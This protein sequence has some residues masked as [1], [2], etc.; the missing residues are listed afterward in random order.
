MKKLGTKIII[1]IVACSVIMTIM[2]GL[3]VMLVSTK[4]IDKEAKDKLLYISSSRGNEF[5]ILTAKIE[6]TVNDVAQIILSEIDSSKAI[7]DIYMSSFEQAHANMFLQI[8]ESKK[9]IVGLYFNFDPSFT[10]GRKG[11][12][13]AYLFDQETKQTK[14]DLDSYGIEEYDVANEDL[15][16][17][18]NPVKAGHG[19]WSMPYVDSVSNVNMISYTMPV[20]LNGKLV[21]V[22]GADIS[23]EY[24]RSLILGTKLYDTGYAF[25]LSEDLTFIV[26]KYIDNSETKLDTMENSI[27]K[28]LALDIKSQKQDITEITYR[29]KKSIM[30]YYKLDNGMVVG[31]VAPISE[32]NKSSLEIIYLIIAISLSGIILSFVVGFL[33]SRR[34]SIPIEYVSKV[35]LKTSNFD[36]TQKVSDK[37]LKY[38]DEIGILSNSIDTMQKA[39]REVFQDLV[40]EADAVKESSASTESEINI[41]REDINDISATTEELSA[42]MEETSASAQQM[43]STS[44]NLD[45]AVL[46]ISVKAREGAQA[47]MVISERAE[48]LK[49]NA[50]ISQKSAYDTHSD[51]DAKLQE[52]I[53]Q[54]KAIEQ[55]GTI[56]ES[57]LQITEQTN[58]L[59]LN[60]SI[61]AARA[62]EAGKGFAVVASEIRKL[63]DDSKNAVSQIQSVANQVVYSVENLSNN[64]KHV[65]EFIQMQVIK[66]YDAM[67]GIGEQYCEDA[68]Y[69]HSLVNEFS[70]ASNLLAISIQNMV[71]S[72]N[73]ISVANND[74]TMAVQSIVEKTSDVSDKANEVV[75]IAYSTKEI[76][77]R[78]MTIMSKFKV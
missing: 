6:N 68:K 41:L 71:K 49:T 54:A 20:Y 39:I 27:Y 57:I 77:H 32:V 35:L 69:V 38:K 11:F 48:Q 43:H 33:I 74:E 76:S 24:L 64:S 59:A 70:T 40:T 73:D 44:L 60:A 72:I 50:I 7:D 47:S 51:I 9:D 36:F 31:V 25:V 14:V 56:S 15:G 46:T 67:V 10:S 2:I 75:K 1:G 65:L 23:F 8:G 61:E 62:G 53:E 34:I 42:S 78:I 55:I 17:Y 16:W 63:A 66:D 19:L 28:K 58:L 22:A 30:G 13:I 21:G 37:F 12:D 18:N 26:D 3:S 45:E 4:A 5:N 52:A 29:G